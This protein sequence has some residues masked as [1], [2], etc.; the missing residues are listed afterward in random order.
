LKYRLPK[1]GLQKAVIFDS[2]QHAAV[3]TV[4]VW[5]PGRLDLDLGYLAHRPWRCCRDN[6]DQCRLFL[7]KHHG[8]SS[9]IGLAVGSER[10]MLFYQM[11]AHRMRILRFV[12]SLIVIGSAMTRSNG[13]CHRQKYSKTECGAAGFCVLGCTLSEAW[14]SNAV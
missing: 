5:F 6:L 8:Q 12:P 9:R 14:A 10:S 11:P 13:A 1:S 3:L 7:E 2:A 4:A